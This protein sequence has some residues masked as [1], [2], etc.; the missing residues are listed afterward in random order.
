MFGRSSAVEFTDCRIN[1][2]WSAIGEIARHGEHH[3]HKLIWTSQPGIMLVQ[4]LRELGVV[5]LEEN[6]LPDIAVSRYERLAIA[7]KLQSTDQM[8]QPWCR[9]ERTPGG[10]RGRIRSTQS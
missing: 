5:P 10:R 8:Q 1:L 7:V 3:F 2:Q 6:I 4:P 9:S